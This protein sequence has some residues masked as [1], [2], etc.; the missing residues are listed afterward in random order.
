MVNAYIITSLSTGA[1]LVFY[2]ILI[3]P[4]SIG[5]PLFHHP[6]IIINSNIIYKGTYE[7]RQSNVLTYYNVRHKASLIEEAIKFPCTF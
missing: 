3:L 2:L 4:T 1:I 7:K 5:P 6:P